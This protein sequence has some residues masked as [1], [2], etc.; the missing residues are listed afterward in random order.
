MARLQSFRIALVVS[1]L[2]T[3]RQEGILRAVKASWTRLGPVYKQQF[4]M[5]MFWRTL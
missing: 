4:H 1:D 5:E 2:E 3:R